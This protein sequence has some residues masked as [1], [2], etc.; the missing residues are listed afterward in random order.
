M[1]RDFSAGRDVM[2]RRYLVPEQYF[3]VSLARRQGFDISAT[4]V[5]LINPEQVPADRRSLLP[6]AVSAAV[7]LALGSS[8]LPF[9]SEASGNA[10]MVL[11]PGLSDRSAQAAADR[12]ATS[13]ETQMKDMAPQARFKIKVQPI[14]QHDRH[15]AD[16]ERDSP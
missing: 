3:L 1:E 9:E 4:T 2:P 14:Y 8:S 12:L 15:E 6:A 16:N 10:F 5:Q 7:R 13:L 11:M